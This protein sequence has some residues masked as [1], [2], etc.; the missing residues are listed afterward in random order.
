MSSRG[1][2]ADKQESQKREIQEAEKRGAEADIDQE[3]DN[4][5]QSSQKRGRVEV[6]KPAARTSRGE[7]ADIGQE[8]DKRS[9]RSRKRCPVKACPVQKPIYGIDEAKS[10]V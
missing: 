1:E 8:G 3:A 10:E 5:V 6:T 7:E 4:T 9:P 2:K